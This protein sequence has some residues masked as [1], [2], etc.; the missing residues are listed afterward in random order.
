MILL[1]E[2]VVLPNVLALALH[3]V[4]YFTNTWLEQRLRTFKG[5]FSRPSYALTNKLKCQK[6]IPTGSHLTQMSA[7]VANLNATL[8][9]NN[10]GQNGQNWK[11]FVP[12][13]KP[14]SWGFWGKKNFFDFDLFW[15]RSGQ[16]REPTLKFAPKYGTFAPF[17]DTPILTLDNFG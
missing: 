6:N 11:I 16:N 5:L 10:F 3:Q 17:F 8:N 13:I 1:L 15:L 7:G 9:L 14:V 4:N 2:L 12:I